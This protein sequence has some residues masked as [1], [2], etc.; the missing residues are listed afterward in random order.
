[1]RSHVLAD[2]M[3]EKAYEVSMHSPSDNF[4]G[5]VK[6]GN[7]NSMTLSSKYEL[8][9]DG[10]LCSFVNHMIKPCT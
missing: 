4:L 2:T 9:F 8:S 3:K 10:Y 1:M 6:F 7:H 5:H